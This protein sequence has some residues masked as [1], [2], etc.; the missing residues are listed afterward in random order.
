MKQLER[1]SLKELIKYALEMP[2]G[3]LSQY[4]LFLSGKI[5]EVMTRGE[6]IALQLADRAC[7]GDLDAI[8]E[9]RQWV[10]EDPKNPSAGNTNY[11]QFLIQMAQG[12]PAPISPD[13]VRGLRSIAE[14][15]QVKVKELPS[16]D[17][18]DDLA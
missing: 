5:P 17:I 8:K 2:A 13:A 7:H 16:S 15:I 9:L 18:L 12:A 10:V 1:Q 14:T 4:T 3:D 6:L 11:Y